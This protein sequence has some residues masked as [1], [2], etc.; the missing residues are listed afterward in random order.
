MNHKNV[1][2]YIIVT[3]SFEIWIFSC[4]EKKVNP[5]HSLYDFSSHHRNNTRNR[6]CDLCVCVF[7]RDL[8]SMTFYW[9]NFFP[10][11]SSNTNHCRWEAVTIF[12]CG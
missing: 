12:V 5:S 4:A 2:G 3:S 1:R 8:L 10:S 6:L 11:S 7:D 9:G